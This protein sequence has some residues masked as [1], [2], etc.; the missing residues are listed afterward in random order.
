M[1]EEE[2]M[3]TI[4]AEYEKI[5]KKIK[6][7]KELLDE[8]EPLIIPK[9]DDKRLDWFQTSDFRAFAGTVVMHARELNKAATAIQVA[10]GIL[11]SA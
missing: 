5:Q 8:Y 2:K 4:A 10:A 7:L 1:A 3:A 6:A 9:L 11:M